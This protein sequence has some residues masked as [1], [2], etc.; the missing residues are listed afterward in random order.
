MTRS[1]AAGRSV[2]LVVHFLTS[3]DGTVLVVPAVHLLAS[4]G[5]TVPH[6]MMTS[7]HGTVLASYPMMTSV[8]STVL[9]A[10]LMTTVYGTIHVTTVLNLVSGI[11]VFTRL[12]ADNTVLVVTTSHAASVDTRGFPR[13]R[14]ALIHELQ[15][16]EREKLTRYGT[17]S[18]ERIVWIR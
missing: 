11:V 14:I 10:N 8:H 12:V 3:L 13:R 1:A 16:K 4:V 7:L 17:S 18:E 15:A 5:C 6:L 2:L 9:V